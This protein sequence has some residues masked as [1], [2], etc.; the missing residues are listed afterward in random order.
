MEPTIFSDDFRRVVHF[1]MVAQSSQL[2]DETF[3]QHEG[4]VFVLRKTS[5]EAQTST[6]FRY[7]VLF[8]SP[9]ETR[10]RKC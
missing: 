9:E 5:V 3:R 1:W 8:W 2:T 6:H 7:K 4:G 10:K